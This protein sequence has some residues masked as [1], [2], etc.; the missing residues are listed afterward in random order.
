MT[1]SLRPICELETMEVIL[2]SNNFLTDRGPVGLK[3]SCL[4]NCVTMVTVNSGLPTCEMF[5][6]KENKSKIA[7]RL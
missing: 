7:A 5:M 6:E 2:L 1:F 3:E 4:L